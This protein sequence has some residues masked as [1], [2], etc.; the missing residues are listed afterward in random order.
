MIQCLIIDDEPL[1]GQLLASYADKIEYLNVVKVFQNP[2]KALAFLQDQPIDL[3]FLDIQMPQLKGTDLAKIIGDKIGIIFTTA[4]PEHA[5]EGF[6][7]NA[8]DYLVKPIN[9]QR[10]LAAT[11]RFQDSAQNNTTAKTEQGSGL[12]F[13]KTENRLQKIKLADILYLKS[14]GDYVQIFTVTQKIMTL[15]NMKAF[16]ER[17]SKNNFLRVHRSYIIALDK[18][19]FVQN[20]KIK[21]KDQLIP[22]S[23]TYQEEFFVKLK[24]L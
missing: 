16:E 3:I 10:F 9:F 17:L 12:L 13:V 4:Y 22:L 11:T 1:A 20:Q 21:I 18:I 8:V 23:R 7:L 5:V 24:E 14:L 15:E 19:D 6:E 2:I